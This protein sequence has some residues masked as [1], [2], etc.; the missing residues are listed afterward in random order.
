MTIIRENLKLLI[1]D[2]IPAFY[3][4]KTTDTYPVPTKFCALAHL[5]SI[6]AVD[7]I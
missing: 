4:H 1:I 6:Q 5:V 7:T 2:R 3:T